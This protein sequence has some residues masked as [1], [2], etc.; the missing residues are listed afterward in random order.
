MSRANS[1]SQET[2]QVDLA[3]VR[4]QQAYL[5]EIAISD[6][7][8][9][10]DFHKLARSITENASGIVDVERASVWLFRRGG[11]ELCCIDLFEAS[12]KTHTDGQVLVEDQFRNEFAA[13]N[14]S[15]YID[16]SDAL[17][18]ARTA[19]YVEDYLKPLGI[20]AML[21]AV[22]LHGGE[23]CGVLCLE[24]V[25]AKRVWTPDELAFACQLADQ[26][27]LTQT[28][29]FEKRAVAT[30]A[31]SEVIHRELIEGIE[32]IPCTIDLEGVV[33]YMGPQ[34]TRYGFD[35]DEMIGKPFAQFIHAD[36]RLQ[37]IEAFRTVLATQREFRDE[38]RVI[39]PWAGT[40]WFEDSTRIRR[41]EDGVPN[42]LFVI[43]RDVTERRAMAERLQAAKEGA[44][45]ASRAKSEFLA[46]MSHE[47]R[48]PMTA[49]L[50]YSD[51]LFEEEKEASG[52]SADRTTA[53]ESIRRNG[54]HLLS[55]INSLLELSQIESG[56][57][58]LE[59]KV[60]RPLDLAMDVITGLKANAFEKGLTLK[61]ETKGR[62]PDAIRIDPVRLRQILFNLV[63]NAIK[64]TDRGEIR[65]VV[66]E[67][68]QGVE[69]QL[70]FDVIDTGIGIPK[71]QVSRLFGRFVQGESGV[72]RR[73][74]GAGLGLA[75]SQR[76]AA[77][78]GGRIEVDS[79][80]GEGS[81][82]RLR[83]RALPSDGPASGADS[84]LKG[85]GQS[86]NREAQRELP[87]KILEGVQVLLAE[88]GIDNQRLLSFVLSR[89]GATVT[90]A[91]NG[92]LAV[93]EVLD[94]IRSANPYDAILMDMQMPVMDGYTATREL[95]QKGYHGPI[96]AVTAHAIA[97]DRQK[98]LDAGCD[99]YLSKPL[100]HRHLIQVVAELV[101]QG[102]EG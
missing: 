37:L 56:E 87:D 2:V 14:A 83:V 66:S 57:L 12:G 31:A 94:P 38:F 24:H 43:L 5:A 61:L 21:D 69:R 78:L 73:F 101:G 41:G 28:Y 9:S 54:D 100:N 33:T 26:L 13:L 4:R 11:K 70:Q 50:G 64:F 91:E 80:T 32:D 51:L 3:R 39:T 53:W 25:G 95:R 44:E 27:A 40:I 49:I 36:D 68:G 82:F 52:M 10:G 16:A 85:T 60:C 77:L 97:G 79:R 63:G 18:D 90:V 58:Q 96:V 55:L 89:A 29:C 81:R 6:L 7:V 99:E 1:P 30:V 86:G 8:V 84:S 65:V 71:E 59:P 47:I 45:A 17:N 15:R 48:T 46:N 20:T 88:D 76:L 67:V 23:A 62:I 92:L 75:I 98:C 93:E 102:V 19:G 42:G 35:R 74:G 72:N 22:I 34:V